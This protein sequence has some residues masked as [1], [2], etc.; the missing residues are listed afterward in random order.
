MTVHDLIELEP[1]GINQQWTNRGT[2]VGNGVAGELRWQSGAQQL[3]LSSTWQKATVT[4]EQPL[5]PALEL[6]TASAPRLINR[7]EW[8]YRLPLVELGVAARYASPRRAS[9]SNTELDQAYQLPGY[10]LWRLHALHQ[11]GRQR[12]GLVLDNAL[13][14]HYSEPGYGGVDLPGSR[15]T[16]WLSWSWEA[17]S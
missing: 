14:R 9:D 13:D 5:I 15:R 4:I 12:L 11:W 16:L 7:G 6:P 8:L 17:G 1:F 3:T 2:E 10:T